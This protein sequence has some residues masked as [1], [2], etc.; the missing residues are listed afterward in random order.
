M[1]TLKALKIYKLEPGRSGRE[2]CKV[3]ASSN[4]S[5]CDS[6]LIGNSELGYAGAAGSSSSDGFDFV[7]PNNVPENIR[8]KNPLGSAGLLLNSGN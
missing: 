5:C 6:G 4:V 7:L 2:N 8:P 3:C 1:L